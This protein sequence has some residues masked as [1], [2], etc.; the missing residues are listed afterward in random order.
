MKNNGPKLKWWQG[1]WSTGALFGLGLGVVT[2]FFVR[3]ALGAEAPAGLF[4]LIVDLP[5][6]PFF[7][8]FGWLLGLGYFRTSGLILAHFISWILGGI[9]YA[10]IIG[11]IIDHFQ[12]DERYRLP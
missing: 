2:Y 5:V 6:L 8:F 1:W 4:A 7:I 10:V 3:L 11:R 12:K 9:V